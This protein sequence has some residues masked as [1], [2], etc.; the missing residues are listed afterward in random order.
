MHLCGS[1]FYNFVVVSTFLILKNMVQRHV[2]VN[3]HLYDAVTLCCHIRTSMFVAVHS[4]LC[5][6]MFG[7]FCAVRD[8]WSYNSTISIHAL[9]V[10]L[11]GSLVKYVKDWSWCSFI[12]SD[13]VLAL[14]AVSSGHC[15]EPSASMKD[16]K[17]LNYLKL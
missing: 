13:S 2:Y 4:E 5:S 1:V 3:F 7:V 15:S 11:V 14:V 10:H 9:N 6:C 16:G 12:S 17:S 8:L